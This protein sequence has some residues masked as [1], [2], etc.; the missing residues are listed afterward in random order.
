M[1]SEES[2]SA[3]EQGGIPGWN[4]EEWNGAAENQISHNENSDQHAEEPTVSVDQEPQYPGD[5]VNDEEDEDGAEYDPESV[6]ISAPLAPTVERPASDSPRPSKKPKTAGGFIVNSSDDEDDTP[7]PAPMPAQASDTLK[8]IPSEAQ[9]RPFSHSPLQQTT[10][11]QDIAQ[12]PPPQASN[13]PATAPAIPDIPSAAAAR[14]R[15]P[16][17]IIGQYEDRIKQDPR[18]DLDAWLALIDEHKRRYKTEDTRAVY[19]RFLE[20]FPQA[21]SAYI[22]IVTPFSC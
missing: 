6:T 19:E 1:A 16:T 14:T 21:V 3:S 17:D 2:G 13:V 4:A 15:L 5:E 12:Y 11:S 10:L 9:S 18:G 20:V 22:T 7:T 8:P